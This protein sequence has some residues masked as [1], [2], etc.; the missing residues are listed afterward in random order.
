MRQKDN[1]EVSFSLSRSDVSCRVSTASWPAPGRLGSW[2]STGPL[3]L[4]ADT[5]QGCRR[6]DPSH[7]GGATPNT[8]LT[9]T[10]HGYVRKTDPSSFA[11]GVLDEPLPCTAPGKYCR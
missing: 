1:T 7:S 3:S 5:K 9:V 4:Y 10:G 8:P 11:I 2:R 6:R